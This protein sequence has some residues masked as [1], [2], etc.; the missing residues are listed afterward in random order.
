MPTWSDIQEWTFSSLQPV[1]DDLVY[2]RQQAARVSASMLDLDAGV[3][4]SGDG[5]AAAGTWFSSLEDTSTLLLASLGELLT[6]TTAMQNRMGEVEV[7]V[8]EILSQTS[9]HEY[10]IAD[11]GTVTDPRPQEADSPAEPEADPGADGPAGRPDRQ[12]ALASAKT[13]VSQ[14]LTKA[15]IADDAYRSS[16]TRIGRG[17]LSRTRPPGPKHSDRGVNTR[18]VAAWWDSLTE[19]ERR[20]Q[21]N[22]HASVIGTLDGVSGRDRDTANRARLTNDIENVQKLIDVEHQKLLDSG[23]PYS[24]ADVGRFNALLA[25]REELEELAKSIGDADANPPRQLLLYDPSTGRPGRMT[26]HVAVSIGDVDTAAHISTFVPGMTINVRDS[27]VAYA[28]D[29]ANLRDQSIQKL[30]EHGGS[31][32]ATIVWQGYDIPSTAGSAPLTNMV[33]RGGSDLRSFHEGIYDSRCRLGGSSPPHISVLGYSSYGSATAGR[34]LGSIRPGVVGDFIVCGS[35]RGLQ[36]TR[37]VNVP[38]GHTYALRYGAGDAGQA[39]MPYDCDLA[40]TAGFTTLN[41]GMAEPR[42]AWQDPAAHNDYLDDQAQARGHV[43]DV[44]TGG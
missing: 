41:P 39:D 35:S 22:R 24:Q 8:L 14:A 20:L 2:Y 3:E 19:E 11:D 43:V 29:M 34:A 30:C 10:A 31:N 25:Q 36:D 7:L 23:L 28:N 12:E 21:I 4:W 40:F 5:A 27:I 44:V 13:L 9:H 32:V 18:E 37:D 42:W 17:R 26:L 1:V 38:E 16:L 6:V 15:R 33:E